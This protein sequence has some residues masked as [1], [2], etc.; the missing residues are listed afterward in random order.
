L[1]IAG[2]YSSIWYLKKLLCLKSKAKTI[3]PIHP[4][5]A[6]WVRFNVV[7]EVAA[8]KMPSCSKEVP[9][10]FNIYMQIYNNCNSENCF[11]RDISTV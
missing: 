3:A 7:L 8:L 10:F 2:V 1:K 6:R 5:S 4:Y 9:R 11:C